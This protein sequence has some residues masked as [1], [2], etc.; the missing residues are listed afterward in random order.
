MHKKTF[1]LSVFLTIDFLIFVFLSLPFAMGLIFND[2]EWIED[3]AM[4]L[5]ARSIPDE[6]NAYFELTS[7]AVEEIP[8]EINEK[9]MA[10]V[11]GKMWEEDFVKSTLTDYQSTLKTY[12]NA[13][14]KNYFQDVDLANPKKTRMLEAIPDFYI[15]DAVHL[16][17]LAALALMKED[18]ETAAFEQAF[19]SV[20]LGQK[21][22]ES[23]GTLINYLIGENVKK[24]GLET[25]QKL[26]EEATDTELLKKYTKSLSEFYPQRTLLAQAYKIEFNVGINMLDFVKE[27]PKEMKFVFQNIVY[28]DLEETIITLLEKIGWSFYYHPNESKMLYQE[29]VLD[30]LEK[31]DTLT[32]NSTEK[33]EEF[34]TPFGFT[35]YFTENVFGE[36]VVQNIIPMLVNGTRFCESEKLIKTVELKLVERT[37]E[38]EL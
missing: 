13:A 32:C 38:L 33:L 31:I 8:D 17:S 7:F 36:Y 27:N 35:F 18:N 3:P 29:K 16:N 23:Y 15:M 34:A 20:Q 14:A 37:Y 28:D 21:I 24:K 5:E 22:Q 9:I 25:L 4:Q 30:Y 26:S 11:E 1:C 12:K 19:L 2:G 6:D 10:H